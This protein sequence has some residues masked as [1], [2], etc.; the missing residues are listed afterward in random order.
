VL[1]RE[2]S[3]NPSPSKNGIEAIKMVMPGLGPLPP[4]PLPRTPRLRRGRAPAPLQWEW[5]L[6]LLEGGAQPGGGGPRHRQKGVNAFVR[7]LPSSRAPPT[8]HGRWNSHLSFRPPPLPHAPLPPLFNFKD[9]NGA[10]GLRLLPLQGCRHPANLVH[11]S[12]PHRKSRPG[13]GRPRGRSGRSGGGEPRGGA[14]G[15]RSC[16]SL[17]LAVAPAFRR[18]RDRCQGARRRGREE[19][20]GAEEGALPPPPRSPGRAIGCAAQSSPLGSGE[21]AGAPR[22]GRGE[23]ER[24]GGG[25]ARPAELRRRHLFVVLKPGA[26]SSA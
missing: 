2:G 11:V 15:G 20:E 16:P 4:T 19:G 18:K 12:S 17:V 10:P 26:L 23:E 5:K 6:P 3:S 21:G 13:R 25:G 24:A 14:G 8:R 9:S 22:G 7:T 1:C